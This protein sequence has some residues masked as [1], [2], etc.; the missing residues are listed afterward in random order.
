MRLLTV[1]LIILIFVN[2]YSSH[3]SS[4]VNSRYDKSINVFS[5]EGELLQV[6]YAEIA[7][8][9]GSTCICMPVLDNGHGLLV[10]IENDIDFDVLLDKRTVD[11][12]SKVDENIWICFSGLAGDGRSMIRNA[13]N[14]C[15]EYHMKFGCSP[16]VSALANHLGSLQ[17]QA[18]LAGSKCMHVQ[19]ILLLI[20]D[21]DERPLG[22]NI[23]V[24]GFD[25]V[26]PYPKIFSTR[27]SGFNC[28][29]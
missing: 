3:P 1:L 15:A 6:A 26:N 4:N 10:C 18:T 14:F 11:K 9:K 29:D 22:V 28:I 5:P 21:L 16:A 2:K 19:S 25:E 12:I 17:H 8:F 13:R 23:L 20:Y 7:S 27:P 24:I